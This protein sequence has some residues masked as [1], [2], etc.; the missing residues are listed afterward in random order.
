MNP[1]ILLIDDQ[2]VILEFLRKTLEKENYQVLTAGTGQEG[3]DM[4]SRY[5]PD[6][7]LL[8]ILLP[9]R[10]GIDILTSMRKKNPEALVITIAGPR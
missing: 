5:H 8:D 1:T 4:Y 9:D 3:L 6:L 10:N 2:R 7:T